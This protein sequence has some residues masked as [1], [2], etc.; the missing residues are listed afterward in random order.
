M[1]GAGGGAPAGNAN[2]LKHGRY[3]AAA[4][5]DRQVIAELIREGRELARIV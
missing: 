3:S 1:H 5:R 2:A 4:I